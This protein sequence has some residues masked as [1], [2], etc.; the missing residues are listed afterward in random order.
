MAG[1]YDVCDLGLDAA[2]R[3]NALKTTDA[4][5]L[6][7]VKRVV[8]IDGAKSV[9]WRPRPIYRRHASKFIVM[10]DK[11]VRVSTHFAGLVAVLPVPGTTWEPENWKT[12]PLIT[13]CTDQGSD[14]VSGIVALLL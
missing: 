4:R 5:H 13:L 12:W 10:I 7:W 14:C 1:L 3:R 8:H 9:T 6:A 11:V 2:Q